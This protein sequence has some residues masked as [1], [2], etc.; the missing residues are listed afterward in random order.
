MRRLLDD[1][2]HAGRWWL[3]EPERHYYLIELENGWVAEV[4]KEKNGE[5]ERWVLAALQD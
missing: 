4:Y 5:E 1:W 3:N 2:S